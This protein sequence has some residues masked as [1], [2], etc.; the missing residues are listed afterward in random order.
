MSISF[1]SLQNTQRL[2][3]EA[4]A[5][6]AT[7]VNAC[8]SYN[9]IAVSLSAHL[10]FIVDSFIFRIYY[11]F[12]QTALTFELFRGSC[13]FR[14]GTANS[15][16]E[17]EKL[18]LKRDVPLTIT[19]TEIEQNPSFQQTLF[20]HPK[21][22]CLWVLPTS[23]DQ[24]QI[25][26]T[27]ALKQQ[28]L[29]I[30]N[31]FKF[32]R[33]ISD[34]MAGKLSQL[35]LIRQIEQKNLELEYKN[36]EITVLNQTLEEKVSSR[37]A[38]LQETNLELQTLFY[39][40]S[41][42]FRA[43]LANIIGLANLAEMFTD[44]QDILNLFDKCKTV[45]GGLDKMLFKLNTMS[46]FEFEKNFE[47][48]AFLDIVEETKEK[49]LNQIRNLNIDIQ[50]D[51][52]SGKKFFSHRS[53]LICIFDN[54]FENA[55][56]F[57]NDRPEIHITVENSSSGIIIRFVDNGI[58]ISPEVKGKIFNMYYRGNERSEGSGLG[59]YIVKKL[60]KILNGK[61]S[62]DS[63]PDIFT[64]FTIELPSWSGTTIF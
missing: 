41:H 14:E 32:L 36:Q 62:V 59:L 52:L 5:N 42:D 61:I 37:T 33:L 22:D 34:L 49:F 54:L 2:R 16:L 7:E 31:D 51:D 20:N 13:T 40:T 45:V 38:E 58:G 28:D 63:M 53:I 27:N 50:F 11:Q 9:A 56:C 64:A 24:Y 17:L 21:I 15:I 48:I 35:F 55:V 4:F 6:F 39:R 57:R 43:P 12:D 10:K 23:A 26:I 3:Y 30:E 46:S 18:S 44:D 25:V 29:S 8:S 47:K 19:K 60:V 1:D